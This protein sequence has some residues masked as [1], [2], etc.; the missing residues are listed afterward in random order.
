M[1]ELGAA[2]RLEALYQGFCE[3]WGY[4]SLTRVEFLRAVEGVL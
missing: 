3:D 2:I 4:L 1:H